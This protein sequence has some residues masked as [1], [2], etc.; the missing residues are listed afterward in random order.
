MKR[1]ADLNN[2]SSDLQALLESL[3]GGTPW[4][5]IANVGGTL[6]SGL[7]SLFGGESPEEKRAKKTYS[8]AKNRLG[9]SVLEPEQYLADYM[10]ALA[11]QQNR[12]AERINQRLGLDSGAAQTDLAFKMQAPI[13][14]FLLNAKQQNDVLTSQND[15]ML[16]QLMAGLSR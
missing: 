2:Q 11:P 5:A 4:G 1:V 9:Q 12:Q 13:A 15:N 10:R 7:G 14:Q 8:L 6:L 3:Q 16:L